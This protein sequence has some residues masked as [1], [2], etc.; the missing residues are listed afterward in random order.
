M[1]CQELKRGL[2]VADRQEE[3]TAKQT[4]FNDRERTNGGGQT[5]RND[6]KTDRHLDDIESF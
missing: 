4:Q 6:C 3:M 1:T 2:T 5:R